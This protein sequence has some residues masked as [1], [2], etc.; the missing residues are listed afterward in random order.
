M[1][2]PDMH[3]TTA[4]NWV[5]ISGEEIWRKSVRWLVFDGPDKRAKIA[6]CGSGRERKAI[7]RKDGL[8]GKKD[9]GG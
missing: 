8:S 4:T 1:N 6:P 9:Y 3:I 2:N 5:V 7:A